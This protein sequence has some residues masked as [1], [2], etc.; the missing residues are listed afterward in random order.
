[1]II[2]FWEFVS[3]VGGLRTPFRNGFSLVLTFLHVG[4]AGRTQALGV[5]DKCFYSL[6]RITRPLGFYS[7]AQCMK[8]IW[9]EGGT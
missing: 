9:F 8:L 7:V 2:A 5:D 3:V 1:M 4:S 6:K